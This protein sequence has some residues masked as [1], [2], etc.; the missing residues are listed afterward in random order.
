MRCSINRTSLEVKNMNIFNF[1]LWELF[2]LQS[3][4]RENALYEENP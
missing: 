3:I 1:R 2:Y 4:Y